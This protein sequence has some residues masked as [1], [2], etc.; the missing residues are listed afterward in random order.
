METAFITIQFGQHLQITWAVGGDIMGATPQKDALMSF[1]A[2]CH[3]EFSII[4]QF[5]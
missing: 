4:F 1:I 2:N 5:V 3:P